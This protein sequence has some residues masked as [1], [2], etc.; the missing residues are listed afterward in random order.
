M[1]WI[2]DTY[3]WH[4]QH[5]G[6]DQ[7]IKH[8]LTLCPE[9]HGSLQSQTGVLGQ[10]TRRIVSPFMPRAGR[11]QSFDPFRRS[12]ELWVRLHVLFNRFDLMHIVDVERHFGI[13]ERL[14]V[15]PLPKP[16]IGTVHT[17]IGWWRKT[18]DYPEIVLP[19]DALIVLT[20]HQAVYF[21]P[22]LPGKVHCIR[23][24]VDIDFF[25]PQ[26][27][28]EENK[29]GEPTFM[30]CGF[31]LRDFQ[32]LSRIVEKVLSAEPR[33]RFELVIPENGRSDPW[34][35]R[36]MG[37]NRV[38]WH[39]GIS[40]EELRALYCHAKALVLPLSDSTTNT[41]LVEGTA[42]GLPVVVTDV[43]GVSEYA[44]SSF[45]DLLPAED[46]EGMAEA[47]LRLAADRKEWERR[48]EAAR[49][50]SEQHLDWRKIA[51]QTLELY[52]EVFTKSCS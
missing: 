43:G 52:Q 24:G 32:T 19:L 15:K 5:S 45:A 49:A 40:D 20:N 44:L 2:R 27:R 37:N 14:S 4:A 42:C 9:G 50:F 13:L 35:R 26:E 29:G 8:V 41:A 6:W 36:M 47:A 30:C 48:S 28:P 11:Y 12:L 17:P 51:A 34:L 23:Y 21:E 46:A 22:Y 3:P 16:V 10:L 25:R 1:L 38:F 33:A 39:V 7:L 31:W 18:H